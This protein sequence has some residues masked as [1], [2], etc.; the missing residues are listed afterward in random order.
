LSNYKSIII[1]EKTQ[2][3]AGTILAR[4][5]SGDFESAL[6]PKAATLALYVGL[7]SWRA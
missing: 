1:F 3:K 6:W 4:A 5:N 7:N 2:E